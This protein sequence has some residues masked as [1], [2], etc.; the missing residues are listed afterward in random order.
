MLFQLICCMELI[1]VDFEVKQEIASFSRVYLTSIIILF[2]EYRK[3][4]YDCV[5]KTVN[6]CI[7]VYTSG[8]KLV[9]DYFRLINAAE[10]YDPAEYFQGLLF[11]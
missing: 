9:Y 3:K 10:F 7:L 8:K 1:Q 5:I 4:L 2:P 11:Q 6:V